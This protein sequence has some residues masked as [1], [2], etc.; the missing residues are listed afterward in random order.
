M[1]FPHPM[2]RAGERD[3]PAA[4]AELITVASFG[5]R[6]RVT[7]GRFV[8]RRETQITNNTRGILAYPP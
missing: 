5:P 3:T 8:W 4:L 1:V 2:S 6:Q 7:M